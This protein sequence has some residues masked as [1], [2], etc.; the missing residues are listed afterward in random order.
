[1]PDGAE[2]VVAFY[3]GCELIG[4]GLMRWFDGE[5]EHVHGPLPPN[6]NDWLA[7]S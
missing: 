5:A 4:Y 6:E 1:M 7:P 3:E 2:L